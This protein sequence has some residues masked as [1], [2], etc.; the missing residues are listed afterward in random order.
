MKCQSKTIL[1]QK[2][3][4]G[5]YRPLTSSNEIADPPPS[6]AFC[7]RIVLLWHFIVRMLYRPVHFEKII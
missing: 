7:L 2:A 5:G 1:K 6:T 3:V 4:E